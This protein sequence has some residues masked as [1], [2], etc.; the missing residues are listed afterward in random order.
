MRQPASKYRGTQKVAGA[1]GAKTE[2]KVKGR[3]RS[4][5]VCLFLDF[6]SPCNFLAALQTSS[7]SRLRNWK[8]PMK[9]ARK[10][11]ARFFL[12]RF[13]PCN[14]PLWKFPSK[15]KRNASVRN[16]K[17]GNEKEDRKAKFSRRNSVNGNRL[18]PLLIARRAKERLFVSNFQRSF[19]R[20][21][22]TIVLFLSSRWIKES[23]VPIELFAEEMLR[24]IA[25][26]TDRNLSPELRWIKPFKIRF[27][28]NFA[29]NFS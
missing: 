23:S 4:A 15:R 28:F 10:Y 1:E 29:R 13:S 17:L 9:K 3:Q 14:R 27:L 7:C 6:R 16:N 12:S 5:A 18:M 2:S 21:R 20:I 19:E 25:V 26:S 22:S 24:R 11:A 8:Q